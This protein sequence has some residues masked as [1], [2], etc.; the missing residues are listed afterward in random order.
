MTVVKVNNW[1]AHSFI[2]GNC[3]ESKSYDDDEHWGGVC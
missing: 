2:I 1:L 3:S